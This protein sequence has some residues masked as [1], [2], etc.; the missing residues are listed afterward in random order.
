MEKVWLESVKKVR[1]VRE[2][3]VVQVFCV[4]HLRYERDLLKERIKFLF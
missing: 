2:G 1:P 3:E 4:R